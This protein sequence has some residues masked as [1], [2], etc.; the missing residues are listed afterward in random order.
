MAKS[1]NTGIVFVIAAIAV[2]IFFLASSGVA[3]SSSRVVSTGDQFHKTCIMDAKTASEVASQIT[4]CD[5]KDITIQCQVKMTCNLVNGDKRVETFPAG[6]ETTISCAALKQGKEIQLNGEQAITIP[7]NASKGANC[8]LDV[9]FI[10]KDG[11]NVIDKNIDPYDLTVTDTKCTSG[12]TGCFDNNQIRNCINGN[13]ITSMICQ[14][15]CKGPD[16]CNF[17]CSPG[18]IRCVDDL[19]VQVCTQY[20][21]WGGVVT[22]SST[23]PD[24]NGCAG[25]MC[26]NNVITKTCTGGIQVPASDT[27]PVGTMDQCYCPTTTRQCANGIVVPFSY[28]CPCYCGDGVC[29]VNG[30]S[31][32]G[33]ICAAETSQNCVSD[34]PLAT[35]IKTCSDGSIQYVDNACPI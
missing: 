24:L 33:G 27:C 35:G 6:I 26:Q 4:D 21:M 29:N 2:A 1:N 9:E 11:E 20:G 17:V 25:V 30:L 19:R 5:K 12:T 28:Q 31:E 18:T 10:I 7:T 3:A 22:A 34:C 23:V 16:V 15:G 32:Q 8:P 13:W 14:T